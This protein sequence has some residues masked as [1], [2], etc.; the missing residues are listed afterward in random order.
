MLSGM[1]LVIM[2]LATIVAVVLILLI[3]AGKK[4]DA[5]VAPLDN[6]EYPLCEIYGVGLRPFEV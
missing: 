3:L 2:A 4:Y 1:S 5:W 6:K